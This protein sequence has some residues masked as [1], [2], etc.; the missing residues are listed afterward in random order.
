MQAGT[1]I[2]QIKALAY[3]NKVKQFQNEVRELIN[4]ILLKPVE[5]KLAEYA[6][7]ECEGKMSAKVPNADLVID[8]ALVVLSRERIIQDPKSLKAAITGQDKY[9]I[10]RITEDRQLPYSMIKLLLADF[11]KKLASIVPKDE[12]SFNHL[13]HIVKELF[14]NIQTLLA[15]KKYFY[16][17]G[18]LF[19]PDRTL[20]NKLIEAFISISASKDGTLAEKLDKAHELI[21]KALGEKFAELCKLMQTPDACL[22]VFNIVQAALFSKHGAELMRY[23][24]LKRLNPELDNKITTLPK[25][26]IGFADPIINDN[27]EETCLLVMRI[28]NQL[29]QLVIEN[30]NACKDAILDAGILQYQIDL[31]KQRKTKLEAQAGPS[32]EAAMGAAGETSAK[33]KTPPEN[34]SETYLADRLSTRSTEAQAPQAPSSVKE[35]ATTMASQAV[36]V[37]PVELHTG[38]LIQ[39]AE[40]LPSH[41]PAPKPV[42]GVSTQSGVPQV[43]IKIKSD[44]PDPVADWTRRQAQALKSTQASSTAGPVAV[45]STKPAA[46]VPASSQAPV[47]APAASAPVSAVPAPVAAPAPTAPASASVVTAA[48]ASQKKVEFPEDKAKLETKLPISTR[49]E[50]QQRGDYSDP[51]APAAASSASMATP[52]LHSSAAAETKPQERPKAAA[53]AKPSGSLNMM[54]MI[55]QRAAE[56]QRRAAA[57]SNP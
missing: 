11:A 33:L 56:R 17:E 5:D 50:R 42:P 2:E 36:R 52:I 3:E 15:D 4:K 38:D 53:A 37:T 35:S 14:H 51:A 12:L 20:E 23:C 45:T 44:T 49:K 26:I 24:T 13:M 25:G 31:A 7:K 29:T 32:K 43:P 28:I 9:S 6:A 47:V 27:H 8:A 55:A 21:G 57:K 41:R 39:V 22:D 48:P 30:P 19:T 34:V 40:L 54:E 10:P 18:I 1:L 16:R 46:A